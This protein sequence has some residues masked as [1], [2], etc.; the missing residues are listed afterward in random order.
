MANSKSRIS[1]NRFEIAIRENLPYYT[2]KSHK[3]AKANDDIYPES[4]E[5][6][7]VGQWLLLDRFI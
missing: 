3:D 2:N 4:V 7:I 5:K 6:T 1:S